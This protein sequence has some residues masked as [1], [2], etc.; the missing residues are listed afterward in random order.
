MQPEPFTIGLPWPPSVNHYWKHIVLP[1]RKIPSVYISK[2]GKAFLSAVNRILVPRRLQ[3]KL[4][5]PLAMLI[6]LYPPNWRGVYVEGKGGLHDVDNR[7]KPVLDALKR[8]PKDRKQILGCW[9]FADDDSQVRDLR[10]VFRS[11]VPGG[12]AVVTL[13]RLPGEVQPEM[14]GEE[15]AP[16]SFVGR[17]SQ[18]QRRSRAKIDTVCD[19]GRVAPEIA[20]G[21]PGNECQ[22]VT[23]GGSATQQCES[24]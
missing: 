23:L 12:K 18:T 22:S 24:R 7:A 16:E 2:E 5:G 8:R 21:K 6:E 20:A 3:P 17:A 11:I 10:V 9:V 4:R 14:F 15:V 13:S 19:S 1:G